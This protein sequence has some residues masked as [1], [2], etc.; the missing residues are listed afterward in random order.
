MDRT[1]SI[2]TEIKFDAP[3]AWIKV[4]VSTWYRESV[5]VLRKL[6]T[7]SQ[8]RAQLADFVFRLLSIEPSGCNVSYPRPITFLDHILPFFMVSQLEYK[9]INEAFSHFYVLL[10]NSSS[11]LAKSDHDGGA[12]RGG[13][14][15]LERN[16]DCRMK[17]LEQNRIKKMVTVTCS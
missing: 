5:S 17:E 6:D 1:L 11:P 2:R 3:C 4:Y 16:F 14:P 13:G 10:P 7:H 8:L 12:G 15:S 9:Y